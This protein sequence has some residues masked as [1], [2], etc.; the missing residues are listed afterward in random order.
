MRKI[1]VKVIVN[2]DREEVVDGDP[3]TVRVRER[4]ERDRANMAVIKL[5]AEHFGC[6]VRIVSG[7]KSRE[8]IV[9]LEDKSGEE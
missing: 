1:R 9:E 3:V 7:A 6:R 2:S 4:A 5:L 8:K